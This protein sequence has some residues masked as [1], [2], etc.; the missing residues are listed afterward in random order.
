MNED[1][2]I[3]EHGST[4][5][6]QTQD[7]DM[8]IEDKMNRWQQGLDDTDDEFSASEFPLE[9]DVAPATAIQ[10]GTENAKHHGYQE[11]VIHT[12]EYQWLI[13]NLRKHFYLAPTEPNSMSAVRQKILGFLPIAH[14]MSRKRKPDVHKMTFQIMCDLLTSITEQHYKVAPEEVVQ[15]AITLT[16]SA[17]DAQAL[18]CSQ[19]VCQTWPLTGDHTIRLIQTV[20]RSDPGHRN[21]C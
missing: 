19:Y 1:D 10:G 17:K 18:T 2:T 5:G 8:S 4:E 3:S 11:F 13:A 6:I 21:S 15:T 12:Q 9:N 16:G 7:P 20:V 14:E